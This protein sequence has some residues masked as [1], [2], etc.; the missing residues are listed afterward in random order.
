MQR[1]QG[2]RISGWHNIST[3]KS[4]IDVNK[5]AFEDLLIIINSIKNKYKINDIDSLVQLMYDHIVSY[6]NPHDVTTDQLPEQVI[7][8]FYETWL[9]EG[10]YGTKEDFI[11]IIYYYTIQSNFDNLPVDGDIVDWTNLIKYLESK[12]NLTQGVLCF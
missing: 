8:V 12:E 11:N 10:Y 4:Y 9:G 7:D 3:N 6:N 5:I 1:V 2:Q